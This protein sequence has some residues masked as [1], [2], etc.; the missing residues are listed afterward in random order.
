MND[1]FSDGDVLENIVMPDADVSFASKFNLPGD[2]SQILQKLISTVP[3]RAEKVT[4]WGKKFDQPRL[5][6]WYGDEGKSYTYSGIHMDPNPWTSDLLDIK[7]AIEAL[8]GVVFNSALLNYYRDER[9]SM[10]FHSDDEKELGPQPI[11]ASLSLGEERTFVF[12]H[13]R[14]EGVKPKKIKL[15]SGSLLVMKGDT[16]KNWKHGIEKE[17]EPCGPRVNLTFRRIFHDLKTKR[18]VAT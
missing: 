8:V 7:L 9:D 1:L 6:A 2:S 16:Q 15:A 3:W 14:L 10:G 5:I 12:K 11:I 18:A 17:S 4:V 13:K